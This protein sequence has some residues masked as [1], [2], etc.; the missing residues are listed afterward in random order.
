[1]TSLQRS[2]TAV[3]RA[4]ASQTSSKQADEPIFLDP[5][6]DTTF[7]SLKK[8]LSAPS[9]STQHLSLLSDSTLYGS[10]TFYLSKLEL[11]HVAEFAGVISS[12]GCLWTPPPPANRPPSAAKSGTTSE[13]VTWTSEPG[14]S[15]SSSDKS[16]EVKSSPNLAPSSLSSFLISRST[17][18]S[19]AVAA[20]LTKRV[21]LIVRSKKNSTG[22]ATRSAL[23]HYL[24]AVIQGIDDTERDSTPESY[25][26][27]RGLPIPRFAII[28][29]LLNALY[30]LK[31]QRKR[32][33]D[34]SILEEMAAL[35][36]NPSLGLS[37]RRPLST[38]QD[39]WIVTLA[40]ILDHLYAR[41]TPSPG[42]DVADAS[43]RDDSDVDEWEVEFR[44]RTA[45]VAGPAS[46]TS[47]ASKRTLRAAL[48][49]VRDVPLYMAAQLAPLVPD[50]KIHALDPVQLTSATSDAILS[51]F[52]GPDGSSF[53][54]SLAQDVHTQQC[55]GQQTK[56]L[57]NPS[58]STA[59]IL[60]S[61]LD[62]TLFP[63]LGPLS[64]LM[65]RA[66]AKAVTS[67]T[68]E[69][70]SSLLLGTAD[71][72]LETQLGD[73]EFFPLLIRMSR[74]SSRLEA[75]WLA[76]PLAG[77][78]EEEIV[79]SSRQ[80]TKQLWTTFK[81]VLFSY[82]MVFDSMMDALVDM[83]PS[84]TL[85]IPP[86]VGAEA[87]AQQSR[88]WPSASTSNLPQPYLLIV[89]H[90][91][92]TYSHLYWITS[93]F[94]SDGFDVYRKVFYSALDVI[95]RDGEA[96]IQLL[97]LIAPVRVDPTDPST[98]LADALESNTAKRSSTTYFL[99]VAEQLV[100]VLPDQVVEQ[101]VLPIC[102]PYLENTRFSDTF[103][104]AHS[105]VLALYSNHKRCILNLA[106]FYVELLIASYPQRLTA[107]QFEYAMS[108]V[109][110]AVSDRSDS[111]AWWVIT[112]LAEEVDRERLSE[113]GAGE[114]D[115]GKSVQAGG[116][117]ES[118]GVTKGELE[119]ALVK[120][121]STHP[122]DRAAGSSNQDN[123]TERSQTGSE[124]DA[125]DRL[126]HLQMC[127]IGCIPSVNLV[128]LRSA[129]AKVEA[130]IMQHKQREASGLGSNAAEVDDADQQTGSSRIALCQ[131]TFDAIQALNAATREEGL[132]WWL[133][134]RVQFGV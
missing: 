47:L 72:A 128:L 22:W 20:A 120:S 34:M 24:N 131:K 95:G 123:D 124:V 5:S 1:M 38:I 88:R 94:G 53:L 23:S 49:D 115:R 73:I 114:G 104:S 4:A 15:S 3:K 75:A 9:S 125:Y 126:T 85:T 127:L 100:G 31:D 122:S 84:P 40:E 112:R 99:N 121:D 70:I 52:E 117:V 111:V 37:V 29:G 90:V 91:L 26:A 12:S 41:T 102:R 28:G 55:S 44:K 65:S 62:S 116:F 48:S 106:P 6:D 113:G 71:A 10:I 63:L 58:G 105:V 11:E 13:K 76:S 82:T 98:I 74:L 57:V 14:S 86:T 130:Y 39:E 54:S 7:Q 8:L 80:L 43:A 132:R 103:E 83:C 79:E 42:S 118:S 133:D 35:R 81:T 101:L 66:L 67:L 59:T 21:D 61:V 36:A 50:R 78:K 56:I 16:V 96:C 25:R 46:I 64:K 89:Q 60:Q 51:L 108:T 107:M 18:V 92:A 87:E 27:A 110:G 97:E 93:T 129:L 134:H 19:Q 17:S 119:D 68:P 69:Q 30:I 2:A 33:R 109:V 45:S 32:T 77:A